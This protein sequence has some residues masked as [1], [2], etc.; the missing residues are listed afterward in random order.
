MYQRPAASAVTLLARTTADPLRSAS[1]L[2]GE[3]RALDENLPVFNIK[4]MHEHMNSTLLGA[5]IAAVVVGTFGLLGLVLAAVGIYGVLSY[6]VSQRTREIG[7]RLALGAKRFDTIRLVVGQAVLLTAVGMA[8]GL[9]GAFA[10]TRVASNLLYGV[11]ATDPVIFA[12][13]SAILAGVSLVA[14]VVPTW[15]AMRVDPIVALRYE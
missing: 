13:V 4:T 15:R 1:P 8:I 10:L 9:A 3:I 5:K 12:T 2:R 7:L 11:S 6:A 14:A